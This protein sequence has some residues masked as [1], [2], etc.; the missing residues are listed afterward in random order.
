MVQSK[1]CSYNL[2]QNLK[3]LQRWCSHFVKK[4]RECSWA[5]IHLLHPSTAKTCKIQESVY[6]WIKVVQISLCLFLISSFLSIHQSSS[7]TVVYSLVQ[8]VEKCITQE[9]VQR[10]GA[11]TGEKID[12]EELRVKILAT[13]PYQLLVKTTLERRTLWLKTL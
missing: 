8:C 7:Q 3:L 9:L 6:I 2:K 13:L 11:V 12:L 5:C 10:L 1:T 4:T